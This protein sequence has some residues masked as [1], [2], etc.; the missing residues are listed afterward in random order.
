MA[1]MVDQAEL[2]RILNQQKKTAA[3][4]RATTQPTS[5]RVTNTP[6]YGASG[7]TSFTSNQHQAVVPTQAP[8]HNSTLVTQTPQV[9]QPYSPA[10]YGGINSATNYGP[11]GQ[12]EDLTS[13]LPSAGGGNGGLTQEAYEDQQN[14]QL[15]AK[16]NQDEFDR[17]LK[18][19]GSSSSAGESGP[20]YDPAASKA[21]SDAIFARAKDRQGQIARSSVDALANVLGERGIL[22][23]GYEAD[24][25]EDIIE[26][27]AGDLGE[28]NRDIMISDLDRLYEVEDRNYQGGIQKRGQ[29]LGVR[30]SM[31]GLMNTSLY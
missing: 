30:N 17:R 9:Q 5:T 6:V 20:G 16:L 8:Q 7:I 27:G 2:Q 1:G 11:D 29:D 31:L 15:R 12:F 28:V 3:P 22:G 26:R 10:S 19:L 4:V 13:Y 14:L 21:A 24:G 23:G 18:V 25:Y